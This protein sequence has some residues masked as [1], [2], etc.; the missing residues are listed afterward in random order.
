MYLKGLEIRE[1]E[2]KNYKKLGVFFRN[3]RL[4]TKTPATKL[5]KELQ[6]SLSCYYSL[7]RGTSR[8]NTLRLKRLF[9]FYGINYAK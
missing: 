1:K 5:A 4:L 2:M 7:E 8:S 9:D 3:K 6:C